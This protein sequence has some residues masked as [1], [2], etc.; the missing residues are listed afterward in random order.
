MPKKELVALF[1]TVKTELPKENVV[2]NDP[3]Q[4]FKEIVDAT[5]NW[6]LYASST[7]KDLI[8]LENSNF[9]KELDIEL[10]S[11]S[12]T[13][14]T[15]VPVPASKGSI[16]QGISLGEF[17]MMKYLD[18]VVEIRSYDFVWK[19]P[20]RN[21]VLNA[22]KVLKWDEK[23]DMIFARNWKPQHFLNTRLFGMKPLIWRDL[24]AK[25]YAFSL[26]D[27]LISSSTF[28]SMEHLLT[29][30]IMEQEAR[31]KIQSDFRVIPRFSGYSGST[32]KIIDSRKRR[33][34][35]Q[36]TNPIRP[37]IIKLLHGN[38]P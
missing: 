10:K 8:L 20:G 1:A 7:G 5:L 18:N 2:R 4:R 14:V 25:D 12:D 17:E 34:L 6:C 15:V 30:Y 9:A 13:G 35:M 24:I 11:K 19:A 3:E 16:F 37:I 29:S 21:F 26:D 28:Q 23:S 33:F 36:F 32:G 38:S 31:G 22:K 27:S